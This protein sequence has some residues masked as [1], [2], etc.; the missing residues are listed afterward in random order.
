VVET[1]RGLIDIDDTF[2]TKVGDTLEALVAHGDL[3][4]VAASSENNRREGS[5]LLYLVPPAF[6]R[7]QSGKILL[8]GI[9]PDNCDVL[10]KDITRQVECINHVRML[11]A[12]GLADA[13][14]LL[15]A[16]GYIEISSELWLKA[17]A[18]ETSAA[19]CL[20][21]NNMLDGAPPAG[22]MQGLII[23]D[24]GESVRYYRGRWREPKAHTGRF[25]GRRVQAYGA[26]AWCYVELEDGVAIR[27][28]DLPLRGSALRGCD[29]AWLLQAAIDSE[30]GNPQL[31]RER[32]GPRGTRVVELFSPLP[33]WAVRK[34]AAIGEPATSSGCL[35][36]YMFRE[37]EAQE[38]IAFLTRY[39]W[40]APVT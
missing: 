26:P 18:H 7:R 40:L 5:T 13:A 19:H 22:D 28:V 10:P 20:R 6:V 29:E 15:L 4:E 27:M 9:V 39:L 8:L 38:E 23:L 2:A 12:E 16:L 36:S 33:K 1:C 14:E 34:L 35:F 37:N 11:H 21:L 32:Q 25:V 24:H 30:R 3:F 17:P 31:F